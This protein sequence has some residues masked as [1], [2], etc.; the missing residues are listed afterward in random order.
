MKKSIAVVIPV[1]N[2]QDNLPLLID[3]LTSVLNN[4]FEKY[5]I[6]LVNDGSKDQ[7]GQVIENLLKLYPCIR[8]FE[9]AKNYGQH[10]AILCGIREAQSDVI[11]TM[12]D[13][14][15]HPPEAIPQLIRK[16]EEGYDVIYGVPKTEKHAVWRN[17][18]SKLIKLI[19][20]SI[21]SISIGQ[22]ISAFRIFRTEIRESFANY[23]GNFVSIDVLLSWG[24]TRFSS[25]TVQFNER[26]SGRSQYTFKKL[27]SHALTLITGFSILPLQISS[28]MGFA[29]VFLGIAILIFVFVKYIISGGVVPG[30][31]FLASAMAIFAGV[32]LFAIGMLGEYLG[33]L[34]SRTLGQPTYTIRSQHKS[35]RGFFE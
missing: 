29:S 2:S 25:I 14:L 9:L 34:F 17:L 24:T 30:F 33:R 28:F 15:Q 1:Y 11:C 16:L 12:D 32:Q 19:L 3:S 10:N 4:N 6:I 21:M 18:T 13:D 5:E 35:Q 31:T 8:T 20:K 26:H 22:E 7:S 23:K 27:L